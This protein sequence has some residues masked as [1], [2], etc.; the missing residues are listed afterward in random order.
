M[1]LRVGV[2][3]RHVEQEAARRTPNGMMNG[4]EITG[5]GDRLHQF[6]LEHPTEPRLAAVLV[7]LAA[8]VLEAQPDIGPRFRGI[9]CEAE[10][11][12][13]DRPRKPFNTITQDGLLVAVRHGVRLPF[14]Q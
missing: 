2:K 6:V 11:L 5:G 7:R 8:C 9:F 1:V 3:R 14:A 10:R 4:D 12:P 13:A